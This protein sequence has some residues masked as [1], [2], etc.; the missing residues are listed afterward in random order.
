MFGGRLSRTKPISGPRRSCSD[1]FVI[2]EK[3]EVP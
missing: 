1:N 3:K 2:I